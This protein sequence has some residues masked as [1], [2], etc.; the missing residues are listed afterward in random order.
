V[1]PILSKQER[2]DFFFIVIEP[3]LNLQERQD[4]SW[5]LSTGA[6]A[7]ASKADMPP[8]MSKKPET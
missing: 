4:I 3:V 5:G 7:T 2:Q 1:Q 8:F 6:S